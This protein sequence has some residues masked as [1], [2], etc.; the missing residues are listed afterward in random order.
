MAKFIIGDAILDSANVVGITEETICFSVTKTKPNPNPKPQKGFFKK[1]TYSAEISYE[2]KKACKCWVLKVADGTQTV[3]P[4]KDADDF[5]IG[6]TSYGT[7]QVYRFYTIYN[8]TE[9]LTYLKGIKSRLADGLAG[10][11]ERKNTIATLSNIGMIRTH[12]GWQYPDHLGTCMKLDTTI[13]SK[14]DVIKKYL[15]NEFFG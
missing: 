8:N 15:G 2:E 9:L 10:D 13:Q 1:L 6:S 5:Y 4:H 14:T 11:D 12:Y 3:L 7:L